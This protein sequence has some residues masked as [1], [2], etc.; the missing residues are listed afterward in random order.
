MFG[1]AT[2]LA[3]VLAA[4]VIVS[5]SVPAAA[6]GR[7]IA[8]SSLTGV[9][10]VWVNISRGVHPQTSAYNNMAY[11]VG[12]HE[13]V[14]FSGF[15]YAG[16]GSDL[17]DTWTYSA[18]NWTDLNLS[19]VSSP[20]PTESYGLTY[21]AADGYLLLF[22]GTSA[23]G[24]DAVSWTFSAGTWTQLHPSQ[25]P[26]GRFQAGMAYDPADGYVVLYGGVECHN[27]A[28]SFPRYPLGDTW[29][30]KAGV[31]TNITSTAGPAPPPRIYPSMVYDSA[32]GYV[33][34]HGG[35]LCGPC[36][37]FAN[38]TWEFKGGRWT[39]LSTN[40]GP[41]PNAIMGDDPKDG[42]V[43]AYGGVNLPM[44]CAS[45]ATWAFNGGSW[46]TV[47]ATGAPYREGANMVF[48]SADGYD[49]YFGGFGS[50]NPCSGSFLTDTWKYVGTGSGAS[51]TGTGGTCSGC[52]SILGFSLPLLYLV[53]LLAAVALVV[54]MAAMLRRR[55]R[56]KAP[57]APS[58]PSTYVASA[59][60]TPPPAY[61]QAP[62]A[63]AQGQPEYVSQ[64]G[65]PPGYR[66]PPR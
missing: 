10:G 25:S 39:E 29:T 1:H 16:G 44:G 15:S 12:D 42:Y 13:A 31:W 49:F 37:N 55:R 24:P 45:T 65:P 30:Y 14:L 9:T 56:S 27:A 57:A 63:Y 5:C 8:P 47:S 50:N 36:Q 66:P 60:G 3:F 40:G 58:H 26:P 28:C 18:G 38:D 21:D 53:L 11:D 34:L 32:D 4:I 20:A 51:G 35:Q 23:S 17:P 19:T 46:T 2:L 6:E 43:L 52:L 33:L 62:P 64:P 54:A 22:G 48:D 59:H 61:G 7:R 41:P